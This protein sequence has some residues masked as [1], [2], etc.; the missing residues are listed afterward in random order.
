MQSNLPS[1][2][3]QYQIIK[4]LGSG[5]FGD[6]YKAKVK[7][8]GDIVAIKE[9]D[10]YNSYYNEAQ[11]YSD[12]P[13]PGILKMYTHFEQTQSKRHKSERY[14]IV[15]ELME[16]D[17]GIKKFKIS[18]IILRDLIYFMASTLNSLH[19]AGL[20]HMDV[21]PKNIL[22]RE[23]NDKIEFRLCDLGFVCETKTRRCKNGT[24]TYISPDAADAFLQNGNSIDVDIAKGYDIW[25]FGLSLYK[26]ITDGKNLFDY[27]HCNDTNHKRNCILEIESKLKQKDIDKKVNTAAKH[28]GDHV[29][30]I[31]LK[32]LQVNPEE[33]IKSD[34]LLQLLDQTKV[35]SFKVGGTRK[36]GFY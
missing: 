32:C 9:L 31:M 10:S 30:S 5:T 25:A 36:P 28:Y 17:I 22:W 12:Y 1:D 19:S 7:K 35:R 34:E 18:T 6:V 27:K 15:F 20:A 2:I 24:T 3:D 14:Y 8:T 16:G 29:K 4:E 33:R 26:V 13:F 11:I 23:I 21:K